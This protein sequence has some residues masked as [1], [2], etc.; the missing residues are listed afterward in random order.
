MA[1]PKV[2]QPIFS[3]TVKELNKTFKFR[4]FVM[5]E[6]KS[7]LLAKSIGDDN[8]IRHTIEQVVQSCLR[9]KEEIDVEQLPAHIV[10]FL[11]IS[12]FTKSN[13]SRLP[14]D[15]QCQN[16]ITKKV[17]TIDVDENGVEQEVIHEVTEPCGHTTANHLNL[18]K[19][20][21]SYPEDY[22]ERKVI[23][24][25][26]NTKLYLEYPKSISVRNI[27]LMNEK[28]ENDE[29]VHTEEERAEA[30]KTLI[31]E[32]VVKVVKQI[33][34][35]EEEI[36][37]PGVDFDKHELM[38]WVEELPKEVTWSLSRFFAELPTIRLVEKLQCINP[39]CLKKT[40]YEITGAKS[41]FLLS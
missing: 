28:D 9:S 19:V 14:V 10:D 23:T 36:T 8:S 3:R 5:K 15:Y 29:F 33:E 24:I 17:K 25:D 37:L 27:N 41:F 34:G 12:I 21:I 35:K 20:E 30:Y 31:F 7:L 6:E 2:D 26:E 40:E 22:E 18:E 38:D 1:L 39:E 11:Y 16:V 13:S 32:S 4:P